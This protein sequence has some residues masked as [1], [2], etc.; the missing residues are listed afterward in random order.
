MLNRLSGRILGLLLASVLLAACGASSD[1]SKP[2]VRHDSTAATGIITVT[3]PPSAKIEVVEDVYH[4]VTVADP[5]RWL[6]DW[7]DPEV[8]AWSDAQNAYTRQV[9]AR[10]PERPAV[11]ARISEIL[12]SPQSAVY[13][14]LRRAGP[15]GLLAIKQDPAKQQALLVLMGAD[16]N[17]AGERAL[18]DPNA[19]D[20]THGTSI[21]WYEPSHDGSMVAVSLSARGSESGDV[22]VFGVPTGERMDVITERVN[23]GTAG[24]DLAWFPDDSGF[25]YTRYPRP[26]ERADEDLPFYQQVW[27]HVLGT[28]TSED[29]YVLGDYFPRVAEIR[30]RVDPVTGR[31]LVWVQDGDS[32]RFELYLRQPEG[33]WNRFAGFNDGAVEAVFGPDDA[34]YV[35]SRNDAPRGR[36]L[37]LDASDPDL[38]AAEVVVPESDGAMAHSFPYRHS[39][40][41]VVTGER[42]YLV[43]QVGGPSELR[44][45]S[46]DGE[47]LDAPEQ[48]PVAAVDG[49][50]PAGGSD[51]YF[52]SQSYVAMTQW[53]RFDATEGNT[54]R[55]GISSESPVDYSDVGVLREFATS[56]DGTRV[57]VNILVPEGFKKDGTHAIL[58]TGYGAYGISSP[59]SPSMTRHILFEHGMLFAEANIRGGGEYGET[60]HRQGNLTNKQNVFD[61]FAA[62][63]RYLVEEGYASPDRVAIIGGSNGGLLMGAT[64]VQNPDL[65][66]AVVSAVGIYDMLRF[67]VDPNGEFNIPEFGTVKDPEQFRVL[68]AYSPYHNATDGANYPPI[69]MTTGA[70][71]P[72]VNPAHSRK[73]AARLQA[74]QTGEGVVLLRTS[75]ETGH[76][77]GTPLDEI[78]ELLTDIYAFI[79]HYLEVPVAE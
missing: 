15:D 28:P 75:A 29:A 34:L 3:P 7:Q 31:L 55:L 30:L 46:L 78:V 37:R 51:L 36:L 43:L 10:L 12:R 17:P 35:I 23:G 19:L 65:V 53:Y 22:H 50:A 77:G 68:Y 48:L 5:Y 11:H 47:P 72:R 79:F 4:G 9:L 62:V 42:I 64:L 41:L 38:A 14:A 74:A 59:P 13:T 45:Y 25:Y 69:L 24:G 57:P 70:N 63:I 67:E 40:G 16:G 8:R 18:V 52:S 1:T 44:V 49:L 61:D 27:R 54:T 39:P 32:G 71:D 73:F 2:A 66:T 58:V 20:P 56:R 76:G 21:D 33:Q 26:G 6:E 60:W